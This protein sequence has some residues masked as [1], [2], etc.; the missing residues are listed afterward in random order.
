VIGGPTVGG[1]NDGPTFHA[2]SV[3]GARAESAVVHDDA[4]S[5]GLS[6]RTSRVIKK[7]QACHRMRAG[8]LFYTRA[9]VIQTLARVGRVPERAQ[10]SSR[11]RPR[12]HALTRSCTYLASGCRGPVG[13]KGLAGKRND[14]HDEVLLPTVGKGDSVW[15]D[16]AKPAPAI[17]L[18]AK[19]AHR[20]PWIRSLN[21]DMAKMQDGRSQ[22]DPAP[23]PPCSR[24]LLALIAH[25][26]ANVDPNQTIPLPAPH[27]R[28]PPDLETTHIG[29]RA[30]LAGYDLRPANMCSPGPRSW[31]ETSLP[32][33][34]Y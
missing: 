19:P 33:A 5:V 14:D 31:P 10:S 18:K 11:T 16:S 29:P 28:A 26:H 8:S 24:A 4:N 21:A 17:N 1:A 13:V 9:S 22:M 3:D 15:L 6:L 34:L 23:G 27:L 12:T 30:T 2:R 25:A 20:M 32:L 7:P